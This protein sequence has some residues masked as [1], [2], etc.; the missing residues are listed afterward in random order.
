MS[1]ISRVHTVF[2]STLA[3]MYTNTLSPLYSS[4]SFILDKLSLLELICL[5]HHDLQALAVGSVSEVSR[6][7]LRVGILL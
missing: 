4:S 5:V 7:R 2:H 6:Y 1:R 3:A